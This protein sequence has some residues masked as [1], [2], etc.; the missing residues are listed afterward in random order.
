MLG[1]LGIKKSDITENEGGVRKI[2]CGYQNTATNAV[3][4]AQLVLHLEYL[5]II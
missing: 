3:D 5:L 2:F 4:S 1:I